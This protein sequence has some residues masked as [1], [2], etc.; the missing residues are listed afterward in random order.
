MLVPCANN[1]LEDRI[2]Q[3]ESAIKESLTT[4]TTMMIIVC[5]TA[6]L[7]VNVSN[8]HYEMNIIAKVVSKNATEKVLRNIVS[9]EQ[10]M[11]NVRMCLV[12]TDCLA[13]VRLPCMSHM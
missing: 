13:P 4:T 5:L 10:E 7:V 12:M 8:I 11:M 6:Y 1:D 9:N 2:Y 3:H